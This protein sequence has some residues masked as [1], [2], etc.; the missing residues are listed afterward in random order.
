MEIKYFCSVCGEKFDKRN[1]CKEHEKTCSKLKLAK[2]LPAK[3]KA[4]GMRT[5]SGDCC[6]NCLH[7]NMWH[8][9]AGP[10]GACGNPTVMNGMH[11]Y[12]LPDYNASSICNY[13]ERAEKTE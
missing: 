3:L 6:A 9:V 7:W 12:A 2:G 11:G 1:D 5:C 13:F 10:D 8:D 4:L